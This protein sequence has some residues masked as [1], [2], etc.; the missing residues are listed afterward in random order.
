MNYA[1]LTSWPLTY[2]MSQPWEMR[3]ELTQNKIR[4]IALNP[5]PYEKCRVLSLSVTTN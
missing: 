4:A 3:D 2:L 1:G 5:T